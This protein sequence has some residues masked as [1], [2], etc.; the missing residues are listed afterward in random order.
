MSK[1]EDTI[2]NLLMKFNEVHPTGYDWLLKNT[3][4]EEMRESYIECIKIMYGLGFITVSN[5]G[6][7]GQN[8]ITLTPLG[9]NVIINGGYKKYLADK[10]EKDKIEREIYANT[11]ENLEVAKSSRIWVIIG[12]GVSIV[13][14]ILTILWHYWPL[15]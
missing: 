13:A 14:L 5:N 4:D 15:K 9:R 1:E 6:Y 11:M 10:I 3:T 12:V 8:I 7:I 2:Q